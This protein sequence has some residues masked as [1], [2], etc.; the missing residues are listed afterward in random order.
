[1]LSE[2]GNPFELAA[3]K[4]PL[5][6]FFEKIEA[7]GAK[8]TLG[9]NLQGVREVQRAI[10]ELL[11]QLNFDSTSPGQPNLKCGRA[12]PGGGVLGPEAVEA[13]NGRVVLAEA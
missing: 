3:Q 8:G 6:G 2:G 9:G 7:I 4:K 13:A 11:N 10:H 5:M 1:M 12:V